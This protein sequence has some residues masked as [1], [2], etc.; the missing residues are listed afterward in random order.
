M[1]VR[2]IF[3][4]PISIAMFLASFAIALTLTTASF[5]DYLLG[6]IFVYFGPAGPHWSGGLSN[7]ENPIRVATFETGLDVMKEQ[8]AQHLRPDATR[9]SC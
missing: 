6:M 8:A 4:G 5:P 2:P 9:R 1:V 3:L 7:G